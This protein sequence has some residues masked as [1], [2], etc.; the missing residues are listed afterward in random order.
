M[1]FSIWVAPSVISKPITLQCVFWKLVSVMCSNSQSSIGPP[2]CL[3]ITLTRQLSP[4]DCLVTPQSWMILF[5]V[6]KMMMTLKIELFGKRQWEHWQWKVPVAS[7]VFW[8]KWQDWTWSNL[9]CHSILQKISAS[10]AEPLCSIGSLFLRIYILIFVSIISRW[11]Q[12]EQV[13]GEGWQNREIGLQT[14]S[15]SS[16]EFSGKFSIL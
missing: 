6:R 8:M 12:I 14:H 3:L 4:L 7:S 5:R 11:S 2:S 1:R 15:W 9:S 13:K 10:V 16:W